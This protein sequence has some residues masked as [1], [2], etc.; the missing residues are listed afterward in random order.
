MKYFTTVV[1]LLISIPSMCQK[2]MLFESKE[3]KRAYENNTRSRDGSPGKEYWQ[4][5][6]TYEITA[7]FDPEEKLIQ[8]HLSVEYFNESPDS[9]GTMVFKLMQNIYSKGAA[10]QMAVDPGMLHDGIQIDEVSYNGKVLEGQSIQI[11]GTVMTISLPVYMRSQDQGKV[12]LDFSTPVPPQSG[13]RSGTIDSTSFF[14]AYWFPQ[15]AV[16]D[17]IF[18]WD[19]DEYV[20]V[21][22]TYND[23][24]N[25][26]VA[27]TLPSQYNVWATGQLQNP[28]EVFSDAILERMEKSK[29]SNEPVMIID[30]ADFRTANG[31]K[32]TWRFYAE[33]V[34]DFA[35]GTSD[36]Y[37]WQGMAAMNPDRENLCWV[38]S[39]YG[40]GDA[41]FDWVVGVAKRS[42][43]VFANDF[44]G[45]PYPYFK[46]ISFSGTEGGGMEFPMLANN[47]ATPDSVSTIV[48][49]AHELAHNYFPFMMG[50]NERKYGWWDETITT[51][52][53][54][55]L[56][57]KAYPNHRLQGFMNRRFSFPYLAS[58][59]DMMPLMTETSSMMKV[60]P[61]IANFYIKGPAM[62]DGF[63]NLVGEERF[64][65][66]LKDFI[67]LWQGKHPTPYDFFYFVNSEEKTNYNWFWN[68]CFMAKGYPDLAITGASQ[69][70][71]QLTVEVS[72]VGQTPAPFQLEITLNSGETME[73]Q[74]NIAEWK[75]GEEVLSL[76]IPVAEKVEK[77][78]ITRD[79]F[80]D[81]NAAN[82]QWEMEK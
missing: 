28:K 48:V 70:K 39:A 25:Y 15:V 5:R 34:P 3:Y 29:T 82:N 67:N 44:P 11:S 65:A 8:G 23:F 40:K 30:E 45:V 20:G 22:E 31:Q 49:T 68:A 80:Y 47:H 60:M 54:T 17:D 69:K 62:M 38:Q 14:M 55:Y 77:I 4:N 51:L 42:V 72:N 74:Y 61:T 41:N 26:S 59:H 10:R 32:K 43:E 81:T 21:P 37:L 79:F 46:H 66:L 1:I 2:T 18:G 78:M 76:Q 13:L 24:S 52:M 53:E 73:K 7:A 56:S 9:L 75:D 58:S 19:K 63:Q 33:N 27:L 35:W 57:Q 71:K 12:D 16:Y 50:I 6:S 36:H 64:N